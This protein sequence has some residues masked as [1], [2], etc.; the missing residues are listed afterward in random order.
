MI[1][2][3]GVSAITWAGRHGV[4]KDSFKGTELKFFEFTPAEEV[5]AGFEMYLSEYDPK[6]KT[7]RIVI[8]TKRVANCEEKGI[9]LKTNNGAIRNFTATQV[10]YDVCGISVPVDLISKGFTV[11]VP[12][13]RSADLTGHMDTQNFKPDRYIK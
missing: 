11:R 7:V 2:A 9:D 13:R 1:C 5:K 6:E 8:T 10:D 12:M 3:L 4:E